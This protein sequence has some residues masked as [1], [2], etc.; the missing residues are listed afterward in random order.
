MIDKAIARINEEMLKSHSDRMLEAVG[1]YLIDLCTTEAAAK[2]LMDEKKTIAGAVAAMRDAARKK[3]VGNAYAMTD[4]EAWEIV[5]KY[6]GLS[7]AGLS[8]APHQS[9]ASR[10]PPADAK[11]LRP[12]G[13]GK[14]D[15]KIALDFDSFWG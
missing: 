13:E 15:G 7:D 14:E 3:A 5:R 6:Y 9:A 8:A 10:Q 4:E 2:A 11:H 12:E 1:Q